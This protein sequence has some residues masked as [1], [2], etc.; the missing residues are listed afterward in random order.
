MNGEHDATAQT[1]LFADLA[2]YTALTDAHGDELAADTAA[3]FRATAHELLS[4][5]QAARR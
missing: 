2:G 5:V 3:A 1:F 4:A